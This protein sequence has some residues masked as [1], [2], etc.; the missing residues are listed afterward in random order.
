MIKGVTEQLYDEVTAWESDCVIK[1][2]I[3][4]AIEWIWLD[5]D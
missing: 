2:L 5:N 1:W 3:K 4:K